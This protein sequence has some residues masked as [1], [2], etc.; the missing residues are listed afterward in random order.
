MTIMDV[1]VIDVSP[2]YSGGPAGK[3]AVAEAIDRA[4]TD[5]GF[6][7]LVGH[8]V[9]QDLI[10]R[11][12]DSARAFFDLPD[13]AKAE[14]VRPSPD[15][16]RG[17]SAIGDEGLSYSL[18]EVAPG[19]LKESLSVG[20]VDVPAGDPYYHGPAAG[21]HFAPNIWPAQVPDL[22]ESWTEYFRQMER[23]SADVMRMFALGL[24]LEEEFFTP[25]IDRHI[26]MLRVLNYPDQPQPPEPGQL[27]AGAH[28]DYGSL[29]LLVQEQAPGGL[30]VRNKA[31]EWVPVPPV[32]GAFVLNIGDLMMEWTNDRWISTLHRVV[33]PPRDA[34]LGSRRQSIVFFHQPN[35]DAMIE[36]LPHC[37]SPD[38]PPKYAPISSG[39]H[40]RNKFVK[41][42]TFGGAG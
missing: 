14:V 17:Y 19:D 36:C 42:T 9:P 15:Q 26:S 25:T 37:A 35:Y 40:L 31:G 10:R 6:L 1:P 8:P 33:N 11:V 21:P 2:F 27:R 18:D 38:N 23:F 13:A 22:A 30:Q 12:Y 32:E 28:S 39:D 41:Q 20:P 4:C 24:G 5:I 16:V 7:Q 34:A 29:T 3:R